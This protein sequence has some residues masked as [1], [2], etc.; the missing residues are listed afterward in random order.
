[1]ECIVLHVILQYHLN[2]AGR[3]KRPELVVN[4]SSYVVK[5]LPTQQILLRMLSNIWGEVSYNNLPIVL[6]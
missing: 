2:G 5:V 6:S 3:E 4:T 1:M